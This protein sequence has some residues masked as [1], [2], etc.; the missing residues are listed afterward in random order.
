MLRHQ[1]Y[2]APGALP[3]SLLSASHS[4]V[5]RRYRRQSANNGDGQKSRFKFRICLYLLRPRT[6]ALNEE[7]QNERA[8]RNGCAC[9]NWNGPGMPGLHREYIEIQLL[10]HYNMTKKETNTWPPVSRKYRLSI[11]QGWL[12][13]TRRSK[14]V[15]PRRES[16]LFFNDSFLLKIKPFPK[17]R[18]HSFRP[19]VCPHLWMIVDVAHGE[20]LGEVCVVNVWFLVSFI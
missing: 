8:Q 1:Q 10:E 17:R 14:R 3:R 18:I 5:P 7:P 6:P 19:N 4:I 12:S 9:M 15:A 20:D 16:W 11:R 13:P 2:P